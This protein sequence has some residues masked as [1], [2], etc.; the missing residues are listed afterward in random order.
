MTAEKCRLPCSQFRND[1]TAFYGTWF[2]F[3]L[4][5]NC[6]DDINNLLNGILTE[7]QRIRLTGFWPHVWRIICEGVSSSL[8][9]LF[10]HILMTFSLSR[11]ASELQ[12]PTTTN[13]AVVRFYRYVQAAREGQDQRDCL[14]IYQNCGINTE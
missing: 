14:R 2:E 1:R 5:F 9:T 10:N 7:R 12:K 4:C 13:V 6:D 8:R 11:D 3:V